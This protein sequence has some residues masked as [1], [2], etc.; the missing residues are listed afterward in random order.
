MGLFWILPC[1]PAAL[2]PMQSFHS[3]FDQAGVCLTS[4]APIAG[5]EAINLTRIVFV[6]SYSCPEFLGIDTSMMV[7]FFSGDVSKIRVEAQEFKVIK[8]V[9]SS[10]ILFGCGTH[11]FLVQDKDS[12][13]HILKIKT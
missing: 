2:F 1:E 13:S 9:H 10:L 12:K 8:H 7:D 5:Y 4:W 6:L 11:I 3:Y